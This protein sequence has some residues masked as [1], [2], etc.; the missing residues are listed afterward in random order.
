MAMDGGTECE[1]DKAGSGT[2][3]PGVSNE[4]DTS[5]AE[6]HELLS[7]HLHHEFEFEEAGQEEASEHNDDCSESGTD[8]DLPSLVG[9]QRNDASSEDSSSDGSYAYNTDNNN[10]SIE[11][12]DDDS[13]T[14]PGLQE[15][16][17]EDSSSDGEL[18]PCQEE[19]SAHPQPTTP[20]PQCIDTRP[21]IPQ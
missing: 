3:T 6:A 17:R 9:R 15:R 5:A 4:D 2:S 11:E 16:C 21:I 13:T 12:S 14:V 7:D 19:E 1:E 10:S 20:I 8:N 18:V